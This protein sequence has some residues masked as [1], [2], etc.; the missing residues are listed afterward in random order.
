VDF[1]VIKDLMGTWIDDNWDHGF[2]YYERDADMRNLFE[3]KSWKSFALGKNPTAENMADYI[4]NSVAP[5]LFMPH[6]LLCTS[7]ELWETENCC[8][9]ASLPEP[10]KE[11]VTWATRTLQSR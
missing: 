10:S 9:V 6:G 7:V 4:L 2:I 5:M 1:S 3:G 11:Q 8:A